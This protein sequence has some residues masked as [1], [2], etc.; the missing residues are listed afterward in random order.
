MALVDTDSS[1]MEGRGFESRLGRGFF[2]RVSIR[3]QKHIMFYFY[4]DSL[5]GWFT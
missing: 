2:F 3:C 4:K 1:I 5:G